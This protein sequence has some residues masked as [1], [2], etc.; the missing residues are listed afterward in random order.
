LQKRVSAAWWAVISIFLIHGLVVA[1]WVSRIPSI[2]AALRLSNGVLGLTLL[3][4]AA[5]A[6]CAIP[7]TGWLVNRYGSKPITICASVSF[8]LTL[9]LIG[10]AANRA[11]LAGALFIFGA[12]AA[13]MD[14]SMNAQGV[15]VE[16]ALGHP[17]MSRFHALFSLGGMLGAGAGGLVAR[18]QI[19]PMVHFSVA[20]VLLLIATIAISPLFIHTAPRIIEGA[21]RLPIRQVPPIL[22][23]LSAIA[24][25]ILLTEGA[26]ADWTGLY[27]RQILNA[28]PGLAAA[29]YAVFSAAMALF[30]LLGDIIT[31]RL[32]PARTVRTGS[33]TAGLGLLWA[34]SMR[35]PAWALPGFFAAG[36]GLSV[37]IPLVFGSGGRV[38]LVS[39]GAGIATVTGLGYFGFIVG[40]PVIG[41][42][43][44]I[45][46]LR[47]ALLVV[48]L[49]CLTSAYLAGFM[50]DLNA[51]HQPE[52]VV[53]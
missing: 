49:C 24:F 37:I 7:I 47:Y 48:V 2:Q 30:R 27:L 44:Q 21:H 43:S 31:L 22:L 8:C 3:S 41:F 50:R 45:V 52:P 19:S 4:S 1:T 28:G 15:E 39:P 12:A 23:A 38:G 29:G 17:T 18:A 40:P 9:S 6:L 35:S 36:A 16:K 13:A 46:T 32:G 5:G 20:S 34:I 53:L 33:L 25:F 14:V 10:L 26:M 42:V 11:G 51:V